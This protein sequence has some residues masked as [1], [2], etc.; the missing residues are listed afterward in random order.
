MK[1]KELILGVDYA[2]DMEASFR[3]G[4]VGDTKLIA[5]IMDN[6]VNAGMTWVAWRVSDLGK[7]TYRTKAGTIQD[8]VDPIRL[9][10]SP[11]ALIMQRIDPLEVVVEEAHKRGLKV[12]VYYTL[13]DEA[14]VIPEKGQ[15]T[16]SNF[17]KEH[18]EC[19]S[20]HFNGKSFV[21]GVL[22]FGYDSVRE[23]FA[24]LVTEAL[25]YGPDG[26]YLDVAR[27]HAGANAIP[28]PDWLPRWIDPYLCYGY[29]EPDVNR[30]LEKYGS[31]PPVPDWCSAEPSTET[32]EA[33]QNWNR[34]RGEALTSFLREVSPLVRKAG[35]KLMVCFYPASG[36]W[37]NPGYQCRRP[38]GRYHYDWKTWVD[39]GL[40]DDIRLNI[41]HRRF[42]CDD[43]EESSAETYGYA[44]KKGVSVHIDCA[45]EGRYD[46]MK[47][48]PKALP[49]P[50]I[51]DPETFF[52]LMRE[53][54]ARMLTGS[55]DGVFFYEHCGN[56]DRSWE[57]ISAA[58]K[59]AG[60]S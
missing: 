10:Y 17:G 19:Y 29:N 46:E 31:Y 3:N 59:D 11:F 27:T 30:Y 45:I 41:D 7:L 48:P 24:S 2:D 18:P 39:E 40:M 56:D 49:I 8:G 43:W 33:E 22:S 47:N 54:T 52:R 21:R 15:H 20:I 5:R 9:S 38:L 6:A 4:E 55:A 14:Y 53:M 23:H 32:A 51:D 28:V 57:A 1:N 13:F 60:M 58:R 50:K 35:K 36:N 44:Q 37:F 16:E 12:L 25:T 26:I 42:G 34:V